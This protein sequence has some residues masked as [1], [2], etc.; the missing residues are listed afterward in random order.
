MKPDPESFMGI[1]FRNKRA[2]QEAVQNSGLETYTILR[3]THFMTN[4]LL[5]SA[6]FQF[7][8]L[9]SAGILLTSFHSETRVPLFDPGDFG[10]F[11]LAAL[12]A[13][14]RYSGK[15]LDLA[16]EK[17]RMEEIAKLM[18]K[19]SGKTIGVRF[20]TEKEIESQ[21]PANRISDVQVA[22]EKMDTWVDVEQAKAWGVPMTSFEE[23]LVRNKEALV[24]TIG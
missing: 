15:G 23:F 11:V 7:P 14:E 1:Y 17:L 9:S 24:Q 5:P 13:P 10:G 6:L 4:F 2:I 3:G 22:I 20:R 18:E 8:E 21:K 19:I 12:I 16:V